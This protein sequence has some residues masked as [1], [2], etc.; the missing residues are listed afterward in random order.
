MCDRWWLHTSI[1][2][3]EK[4][5]IKVRLWQILFL[6]LLVLA[7]VAQAQ[8]NI[9]LRFLDAESGKPITGISVS[10]FAWDE[11]EGRQEPPSGQVLKIDRNAQVVK[12]DKEGN[13]IFRIY[14]PILKY[15]VIDSAGELRG[16]SA[17]RFSMEE[18]IRSGVIASYSTGQ[19]K[20]CVELKAH[21]TAKPGEI[22]I[23]DKRLTLWD[24]MRQEFP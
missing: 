19:P 10:V 1:T 14:E 18:L 11:N 15:L 5:F 6:N 3:L 2:I 9:T 17:R 7:P 13:A 22:V 24:R 20:W 12:T 23:F 4:R 21:A 8:K 16:C